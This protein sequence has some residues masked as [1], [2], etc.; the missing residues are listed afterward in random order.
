MNVL[1]F[2]RGRNHAHA[3]ES[4]VGS[5]YHAFSQI[6]SDFAFLPFGGGPRKCVGDQFALM[7]AT[8]GLAMLVRRFHISL[9]TSPEEVKLVTGA[10]MHT[11][12]GLWCNV[13]PRRE[14]EGAGGLVAAAAA[15]GA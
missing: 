14:R 2:H 7:E 9:A 10:T 4:N 1:I 12:G 5:F 8:V 15:E 3:A 13:A 6:A 11:D